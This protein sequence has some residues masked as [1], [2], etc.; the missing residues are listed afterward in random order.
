MDSDSNKLPDDEVAI[1]IGD[2]DMKIVPSASSL[3]ESLYE[4]GKKTGEE[5]FKEVL[6]CLSMDRMTFFDVGA[7]WGYFSFLLASNCNPKR[8]DF[9][10][11]LPENV[12]LLRENVG[13]NTFE[14]EVNIVEKAI[15]TESG[16]AK[17][18]DIGENAEHASLRT[19]DHYWDVDERP[20]LEQEEIEVGT[21]RLDEYIES[22]DI[23]KIDLMK[24]DIE[25]GEGVALDSIGDKWNKIEA[26]AIEVHDRRLNDF[27]YSPYYVVKKLSDNNYDL[28]YMDNK[29]KLEEISETELSEEKTN[30]RFQMKSD[31]VHVLLAFS[32]DTAIYNQFLKYYG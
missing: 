4:E 21:V 30:E 1:K 17:F 5:D 27:G 13:I 25:G 32:P 26:F 19:E 15:D 14:F 9:F 11:P 3:G 20:E 22:S 28:Y 7:N 18:W 24:I 29:N 31:T 2:I 23:E 12:K 8:I 16:K 6:K 10:E